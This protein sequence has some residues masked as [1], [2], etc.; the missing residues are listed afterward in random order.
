MFKAVPLKIRL[1]LELVLLRIRSENNAAISCQFI[2]SRLRISLF[3]CTLSLII[4]IFTIMYD[5]LQHYYD[6]RCSPESW[7]SL[8]TSSL[9]E[10]SRGA[11]ALRQSFEKHNKC[12]F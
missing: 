11:H 2:H 9:A 6:E 1:T 3:F 7:S 5:V 12:S 10:N 8:L 4:K